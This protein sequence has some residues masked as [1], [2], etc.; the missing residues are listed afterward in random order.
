MDLAMIGEG[1][2]AVGDLRQI[3]EYK[4]HAVSRGKIRKMVAFLF[5]EWDDQ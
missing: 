3:N 2:A 5:I 4:I 1:G